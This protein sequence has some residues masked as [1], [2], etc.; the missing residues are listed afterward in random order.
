MTNKAKYYLK[1]LKNQLNFS[2]LYIPTEEE[3]KL[4]ERYGWKKNTFGKVKDNRTDLLIYIVAKRYK[5]K[6]IITRNLGDFIWCEKIYEEKINLYNQELLI[7]TP[8]EM[9]IIIEEIKRELSSIK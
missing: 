8:K 4:S 1:N 2:K 5:L 7:L 3:I 6:I 9:V